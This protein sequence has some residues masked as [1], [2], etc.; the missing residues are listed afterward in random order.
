VLFE[1]L[2]LGLELADLAGKFV[3]DLVDGGVKIGFRVFGMEVGA[4]KGEV[5]LHMEGFF[6]IVVVEKND[7]GA[8]DRLAMA[9]E[10]TDLFG[11]EFVNGT[12]ES[13]GETILGA[14]I[15]LLHNHDRKKPFHVKV[16]LALPGPD[17]HAEDAEADLYSAI[18][19]VVDKLSRQISK[20]KTKH[21]E[22]KKHRTQQEREAEKRGYKRR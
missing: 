22:L 7:V 10:V 6:A 21:K 4:G 2:V 1:L 20:L 8:E 17:L 16:H 11:N 14:H 5:D 9:L 19:K 12:G 15:V 3:H 18:D 13:H